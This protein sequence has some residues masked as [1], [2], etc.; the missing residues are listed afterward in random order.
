MDACHYNSKK[1]YGG[2]ENSKDTILVGSSNKNSVRL[3]EV[4]TTKRVID[5]KVIFKIS[6]DGI[7]LKEAIFEENGSSGR[8]GKFI[9]T[10]TKLNKIKSL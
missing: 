6:V 8:A 1:S 5:G 3:A 2:K 7:V 9:K 4:L 10:R